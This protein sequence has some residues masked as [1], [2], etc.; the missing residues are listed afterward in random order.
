VDRAGLD[1][2]QAGLHG[3]AADFLRSAWNFVEATPGSPETLLALADVALAENHPRDALEAL[4]RT[5][6]ERGLNLVTD[7]YWDDLGRAHHELLDYQTELKDARRGLRLLPD[8]HLVAECEVRALAALGKLNE[9]EERATRRLESSPWGLRVALIAVRELRAH[10]YPKE[11]IRLAE[12]LLAQLSALPPDTSTEF[13]FGLARMYYLAERWSE[14]YTLFAKLATRDSDNV[15]YQHYLRVLAAR[16][17]DRRE[18]DRISKRLARL[19]RPFLFGEHTYARASIAALLGERETAVEL[20]RDAINQGP[21]IPYL[22]HG[23]MDL[24]SLRDYAPFQEL[25]RPKE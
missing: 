24:E 10:G 17:G 4:S 14:S 3:S 8:G 22:V 16:R 23:D 6:P 15:F 25:V 19:T 9:V 11:A 7:D 12:R 5:D 20:L 13:R 1:Y 2:V 21:P 18:A